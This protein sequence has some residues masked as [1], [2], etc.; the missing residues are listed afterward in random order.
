[1]QRRVPDANRAK[2]LTGFKPTVPMD[3]II[4]LV[5]EDQRR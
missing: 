5:T 4:G 2:N 1:M 3:K